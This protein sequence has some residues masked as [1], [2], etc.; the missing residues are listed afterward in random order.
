MVLI[1]EAYE[2]V[3][4][5]PNVFPAWEFRSEHTL[6]LDETAGWILNST[7]GPPSRPDMVRVFTKLSAIWIR[8]GIY[9]GHEDSYIMSVVLRAGPVDRAAP[10]ATSLKKQKIHSPEVRPED[11]EFTPPSPSTESESTS[12]ETKSSSDEEDFRATSPNSKSGSSRAPP[13]PEDDEDAPPPPPAS[14]DDDL[15]TLD[16]DLDDPPPKKEEKK[17]SGMFGGMFGSKKK[18]DEF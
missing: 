12:T 6:N 11:F 17:K 8:G 7:G 14:E 15:P 16:S 2:L 1:S 3:I 4:G 5:Y 9:Y 13:P 18:N 10:K